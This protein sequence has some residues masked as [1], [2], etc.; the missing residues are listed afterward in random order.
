MGSTNIN[1]REKNLME[2][3]VSTK[4]NIL[5]TG[6]EPTFVINKIKDVTNLTVDLVSN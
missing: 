2:Y 3:L 5:N 6:N 4:L 1:P